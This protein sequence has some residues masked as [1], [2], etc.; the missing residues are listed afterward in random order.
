MDMRNGLYDT[1]GNIHVIVTCAK[2]CRGA[3]AA[4][5]QVAFILAR[6]GNTRAY[7]GKTGLRCF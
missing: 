6:K 1:A 4:M 5:I 7:L 3:K 2:R